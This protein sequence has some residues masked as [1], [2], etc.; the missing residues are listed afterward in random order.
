MNK[1][2]KIAELIVLDKPLVIFDLES[3][4]LSI[5]MD[6]IIQVAYLKIFPSGAVKKGDLLDEH[7]RHPGSCGLIIKV[8]GGGAGFEKVLLEKR[9][10]FVREATERLLCPQRGCPKAFVLQKDLRVHT[11]R[12]VVPP[13]E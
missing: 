1:L 5:T 4:G 7:K 11:Q 9:E 2:A 12:H 6:R 8:M 3:T 13:E 10:F